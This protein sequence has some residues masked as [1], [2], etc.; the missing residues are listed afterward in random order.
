MTTAKI[1]DRIGSFT[2]I[3][4][5]FMRDA[6]ISHEAFRVFA[7]LRFH[8]NTSNEDEQ[9]F[10]SYDL[11]RKETGIKGNKTIANSL[12]ELEAKG[13]IERKKRFSSST[14]YTLT[15]PSPD[16]VMQNVSSPSPDDV[17]V[18][19][20]VTQQSV[21][22]P[23]TNKTNLTRRTSNK[24]NKIAANAAAAQH[25]SQNQPEPEPVGDTQNGNSSPL[26][27]SPTHDDV[28]PAPPPPTAT[29]PA[30]A[31]D[32]VFDKLCEM[33]NSVAAIDG[34]MIGKT[35]KTIDKDD[36]HPC[37]VQYLEWFALWW[38][39][40]DNWR[41]G[42][43]GSTAPELKQMPGLWGRAMAWAEKHAPKAPA[44]PE[45]TTPEDEAAL[46]ARLIA[47]AQAYETEM[48]RRRIA[49]G[50]VKA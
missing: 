44:I 16:D 17:V 43:D 14:I 35:R 48:L 23:T 8:V 10:P 50:Y 41:K 3:P 9:A 12:R 25:P 45:P 47:E 38:C 29:K 32:L 15:I 19:H 40:A 5:R 33:T 2:T 30:R 28:P 18:R 31:R 26:Q 13:W 39:S 4:N 21:I 22:P 37:T 42:K 20:A 7:V 46:E 49:A 24:T 27:E 6:T 1:K 11:L 36:K 34:A